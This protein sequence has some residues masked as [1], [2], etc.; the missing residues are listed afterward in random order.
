MAASTTYII[1]PLALL[2]ALTQT[3]FIYSVHTLIICGL[4]FTFNLRTSKM[5]EQRAGSQTF[6]IICLLAAIVIVFFDLVQLAQLG[7]WMII[8]LI[9]GGLI[10][11]ASLYERYGLNLN[12]T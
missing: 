1:A 8:G 6:S 7:N 4:V 5:I 2:L 3:P 12:K 11:G 10:L 9:G